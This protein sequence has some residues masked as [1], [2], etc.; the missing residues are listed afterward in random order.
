MTR[1]YALPCSNRAQH[2]TRNKFFARPALSLRSGDACRTIRSKAN[3]KPYE[4]RAG[5]Y[6]RGSKRWL[7]PSVT[8]TFT[9]SVL[10]R[11]VPAERIIGECKVPKPVP[12]CCCTLP[13]RQFLIFIVPPGQVTETSFSP[14]LH[15]RSHLALVSHLSRLSARRPLDPGGPGLPTI[16][17]RG[18]CSPFGP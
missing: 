10:T 1:R 2:D 4:S 15:S 7:N 6:S 14:G 9:A 17:T 8:A 12:D 13:F 3:G 11:G 5:R 18:P 16:R